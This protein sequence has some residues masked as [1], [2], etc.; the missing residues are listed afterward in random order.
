MEK[1]KHTF[2]GFSMWSNGVTGDL[3]FR[4]WNRERKGRKWWWIPRRSCEVTLYFAKYNIC[5]YL[6]SSDIKGDLWDRQ[7]NRA[8]QGIKWWWNARSGWQVAFYTAKYII[9]EYLWSHG[10]TASTSTLIFSYFGGFFQSV[11]SLS[12]YIY[13]YMHIYIYIYMLESC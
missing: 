3:W 5:A 12:L 10:I 4:Q 6:W 11:I 9:Y 2:N 8:R 7:W 1:P 13:I